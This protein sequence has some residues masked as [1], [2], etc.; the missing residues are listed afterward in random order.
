MT[1]DSKKTLGKV[2]QIDEKRIQDHLGELV[3]GTVEETLNGLLD[4]G[5]VPRARMGQARTQ[6]GSQPRA[7]SS[8]QP[9]HL[10]ATPSGRI[11]MAEKG[12]ASIQ[13]P[14]A[15][16]RLASIWTQSGCRPIA[17]VG[18]ASTQE[19]LAQ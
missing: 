18:Q 12:Q 8:A 3:R 9:S 1:E 11:T 5:A 10:A 6:V 16:H 14:Q 4:A 19:G 17:P 15:M 7:A 13:A 2:V